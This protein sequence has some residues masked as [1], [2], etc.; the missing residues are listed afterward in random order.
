MMPQISTREFEELPLRAHE[1]LAGVPLQDAWVVDMPRSRSG[2]TLDE[3]LRAATGWR[4]TESPAARALLAIRLFLGRVFGW[5][6]EPA[7]FA[8]ETFATRLTVTDLSMSLVPPGIHDGNFRV[9]YRFE[10]EQLLE[11]M[12]STVH[13][14]MLSALLETSTA[15]RFYLGVY[16]RKVSRLTSIYMALIDPFRK[17]V[18]YPSLLRSVCAAWARFAIEAE[19]SGGYRNGPPEVGS[20]TG[21]TPRPPSSKQS[22]PQTHSLLHLKTGNTTRKPRPPLM[23]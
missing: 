4:R 15:Y 13:G 20:A 8:R 23:E 12:N 17:F 1:F 16:V 3:F 6:R 18:V 7:A 2:I 11:L 5:D 19:T 9:V 22:L 21:A 10:N 14:A